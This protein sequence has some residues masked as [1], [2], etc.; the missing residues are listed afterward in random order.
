[1]CVIVS[2]TTC[3]LA[4]MCVCVWLEGVGVQQACVCLCKL[5]GDACTFVG[6][7]WLCVHARTPTAAQGRVTS[8]WCG[9]E[10]RGGTPLG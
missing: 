10:T 4:H 3:V 7:E 5:K 9:D 2:C 1:M 8:P 6:C